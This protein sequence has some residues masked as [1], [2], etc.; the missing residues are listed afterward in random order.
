MHLAAIVDIVEYVFLKCNFFY[1]ACTP[2]SVNFSSGG[3]S[4]IADI[5]CAHIHARLGRITTAELQSLNYARIYRRPVF[6]P[7]FRPIPPC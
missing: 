5:I 1:K 4:H 6:A 7:F 2:R 3:A